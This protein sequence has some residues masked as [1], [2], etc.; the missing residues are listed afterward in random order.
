M[1]ADEY[2]SCLIR[3]GDQL[4]GVLQ[5][6]IDYAED[7]DIMLVEIA[8]G[9][10]SGVQERNGTLQVGYV[11]RPGIPGLAAAGHLYQPQRLNNPLINAVSTSINA[12]DQGGSS[13]LPTGP[14]PPSAYRFC[15][16]Q[17]L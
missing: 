12:L 3:V 16:R 11:T 14:I 7:N 1:G 10:C 8:R 5:D 17:R 2:N 6:A 15:A 9:E 13:V 4:F